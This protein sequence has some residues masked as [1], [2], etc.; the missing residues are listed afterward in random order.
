MARLTSSLSQRY[1]DCADVNDNRPEFT[2]KEYHLRLNED[3]TVGTSVV[4]V[5]LL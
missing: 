2:M 1:S 5:T 3:A 4:S